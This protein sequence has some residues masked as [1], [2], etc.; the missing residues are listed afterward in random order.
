MTQVTVGRRKGT[1]S[2]KHKYCLTEGVRTHEAKIFRSIQWTADRASKESRYKAKG[3]G[4][5]PLQRATMRCSG[6][7]AVCGR[8]RRF[9]GAQRKT[10]CYAG[11]LQN[12]APVETHFCKCRCREDHESNAPAVNSVQRPA[13]SERGVVGDRVGLRL[14]LS[15]QHNVRNRMRE[16]V[17]GD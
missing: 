1:V 15:S 3:P 12:R 16:D 9:P 14:T 13:A 11:A 8:D 4:K 17:R 5:H 6:A 7:D 10:T 2:L